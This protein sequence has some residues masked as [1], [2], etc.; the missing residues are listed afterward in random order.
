VNLLLSHLTE[1]IHKI[2]QIPEATHHN[3]SVTEFIPNGLPLPS[4]LVSRW[5]N[6]LPSAAT[7]TAGTCLY[8]SKCS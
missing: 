1:G 3:G 8:S 4:L 7:D 6:S 5:L 2:P